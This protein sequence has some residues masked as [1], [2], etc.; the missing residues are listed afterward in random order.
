MKNQLLFF[1]CFL[2]VV[3]TAQNKSVKS[4]YGIEPT[5]VHFEPVELGKSE[6]ITE[7]ASQEALTVIALN[8]KEI[9][10]TNPNAFNRMGGHPLFVQPIRPK[11]GFKDYGYYTLQNQ[12]DHNLT[13]NNNLEDYNCAQ[14]TYDWASGNHGGTDYIL[15]PYPWTKMNDEIMEIVAAAE[16]TI[17]DKRDHH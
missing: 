10:K 8:K 12:V 5:Q 4:T 16:G 1:F 17:I 11:A 13:P 2:A 15:W 14:R 3:A 7:Q 9:L 6:C